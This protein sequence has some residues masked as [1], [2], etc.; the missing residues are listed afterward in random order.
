[1]GGSN[2]KIDK[3][4]EWL[5]EH[6]HIPERV[7]AEGAFRISSTQINE[8][9]EARLMAKFDQ[10]TQLPKIF[11]D[12]KLSILPITRR[13]YLIG[14]FITH[15]KAEYK[16]VKPIQVKVPLLETID[17]KNLYS[18]AAALF[19]AYN[20]GIIHDIMNCEGV[21][22]TVNGR[23]G[24]GRFS[25][26]IENSLNS[27][28][29]TAVDVINSQVEI[30]A[31][32]ESPDA[33]IV[34]EAKNQ[35]PD[36]ILIR[37]LYYPYR[38]WSSKIM[39]PVIPMFL[40]FSNDIFHVFVYEFS[41]RQNYNSI[42]LRDYKE[43]TFADEDISLQDVIDQ[44][45]LTKVVAEPRVTFPQADS[46]PR[47]LDLLSVLHEE[48]LTRSEVTL[49]YEFDPRQT[50]YYISACEYLGLVERIKTNEGEPGYRLTTEA[51]T[52]MSL[53]YK[54]KHLALMKKIL[55]CPIFNKAF[56]IFMNCKQLPDKQSICS[57]MTLAN[58]HK[59]IND[60]TIE[61]RASTVLG[62]LKWMI[63]ISTTE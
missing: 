30:D 43:Y 50:D 15:K 61:R 5:F 52:I 32:F 27:I 13:E 22:F 26:F 31:G 24:S 48:E 39:K 54:K 19:F 37:Q 55:E 17:I 44:W 14:P 21:Y 2:T 59:Q 16:V 23:M 45:R 11:R 29:T 36:E 25:F 42:V 7:S 58:F 4:W 12:H 28:S 57:I 34:C 33:F 8:V 10:S 41:D 60:T 3:A 49:K 40:A 56:G 1:M 38:L 62:W 6:Y 9:H 46:F 47:I 51:K 35:A 53:S 20:S 63:D 18:E